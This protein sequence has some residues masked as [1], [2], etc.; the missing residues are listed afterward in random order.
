MTQKQRAARRWIRYEASLRDQGTT[1]A[2]D[3]ARFQERSRLGLLRSPGITPEEF[4]AL[5][6]KVMAEK[7]LSALLDA[8]GA[9]YG[10]GISLTR[11]LGNLVRAVRPPEQVRAFHSAFF[12]KVPL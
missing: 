12:G 11:A 1:V 2:E 3:M 7:Q 4:V 6:R 5:V 9:K 8:A 10:A